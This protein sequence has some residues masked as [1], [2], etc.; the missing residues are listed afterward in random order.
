MGSRDLADLG[1]PDTEERT[2]RPEKRSRVAQEKELEG[3]ARFPSNA[4]FQPQS[5]NIY[6]AS[7]YEFRIA[8]S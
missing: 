6:W 8:G 2:E 3:S 5:C 1:G 7:V 4:E